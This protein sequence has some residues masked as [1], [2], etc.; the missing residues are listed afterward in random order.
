LNAVIL[1]HV[2]LGAVAL[3]SGMVAIL[4]RKG[5]R[6]HSR[7][8][9]VFAASMLAMLVGGLG[10]AALKV[11]PS[12]L[13]AT[14]SVVAGYLIATAWRAIR[15]KSGVAGRFEYAAFAIVTACVGVYLW[16][17]YMA[18][19]SPTGRFDGVGQE[20]IVPNL[21][22]AGLGAV[23]DL[24]FI[25]RRRLTGVQRLA[26]HV[27]RIC[28]AM[29]VMVSAI[30]LGGFGQKLFI[31]QAL[32]GSPLLA[33]PPAATLL[34]MTYWLVRLRFAKRTRSASGILGASIQQIARLVRPKQPAF[35]LA[36]PISS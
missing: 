2:V 9:I 28:M 14:S 32:H 3:L 13:L 25:L 8:G 16:L 17:G 12:T 31:P 29:F 6:L 36:E 10:I 23:F 15:C 1:F 34:F 27:W 5:S 18:A 22:V 19:V 35:A 20:V 24:S 11:N 30:F 26:R 4:C 21:L 7:G 33:I